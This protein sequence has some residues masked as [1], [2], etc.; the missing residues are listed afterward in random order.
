MYRLIDPAKG[1]SNSEVGL[2]VVRNLEHLFHVLDQF[3]E[4]YNYEFCNAEAGDAL[5]TQ[6]DF[7]GDIVSLELN[8]PSIGKYDWATEPKTYKPNCD[9]LS[10]E[11]KNQNRKWR[12]FVGAYD[13]INFRTIPIKTGDRGK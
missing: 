12:R 4:A 1:K 3:C 11:A 10:C 5:S 13:G 9:F 2:A 7:D 8:E 6:V